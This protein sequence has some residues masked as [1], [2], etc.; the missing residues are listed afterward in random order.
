MNRHVPQATGLTIFVLGLGAFAISQAFE[1]GFLKGF[2]Q[3]ATV[4]LMVLGV[5]GVS[6]WGRDGP[7]DAWLPSRDLHHGDQ[8]RR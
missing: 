4:A 1:G 2:F 8:E 3:G 6:R 5:W 7:R